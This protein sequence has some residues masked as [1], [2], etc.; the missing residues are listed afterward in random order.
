MRL[1]SPPAS[2]LL[3]ALVASPG[4]A[5]V[6][7]ESN[8]QIFTPG[9]AV[10]DAPQPGTPLGG[11]KFAREKKAMS[12]TQSYLHIGWPPSTTPF[13]LLPLFSPMFDTK[14]NPD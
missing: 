1:N 2:A 8:G 5:L 11:G 7:T 6:F 9:F 4:S 3:L 10:L 14:K 12:H 13:Y